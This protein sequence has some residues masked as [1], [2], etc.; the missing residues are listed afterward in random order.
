MKA[1]NE[2]W[3]S[4]NSCMQEKAL[5]QSQSLLEEAQEEFRRRKEIA[6]LAKQNGF[7]KSLPKGLLIIQSTCI[8]LAAVISL[9]FL[10]GFFAHAAV[11]QDFALLQNILA[12]IGCGLQ[13]LFLYYIWKLCYGLIHTMFVPGKSEYIHFS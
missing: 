1:E 7:V 4:Y 6:D 13:F 10:L 2:I 11:I 12:Y 3:I 9:G 8:S 5:R